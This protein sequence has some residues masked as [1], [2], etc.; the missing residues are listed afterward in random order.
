MRVQP[1]D[2]PG[3]RVIDNDRRED[4]ERV[5]P[6]IMRPLDVGGLLGMKVQPGLAEQGIPAKTNELMN[7]DQDPNCKVMNARLH[8]RDLDRIDG[9]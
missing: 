4:G 2:Q 7:H 3:Q 6:E 8:N 9:I 1:A 5:S